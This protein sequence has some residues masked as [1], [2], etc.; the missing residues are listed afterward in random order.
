MQT[1]SAKYATALSLEPRPSRRFAL[2]TAA[3]HGVAAAVMVS[4]GMAWWIDILLCTLIAASAA[5]IYM[6]H[7]RLTHARAVLRLT[8]TRHGDWRLVY[9][10]G[11]AQTAELQGDSYVHPWLVVLNFSLQPKGRASVVLF[12]DSLHEEDF[13]RLRVRLRTAF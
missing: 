12:P 7:V 13:R 5:Y 4:A 9:A 6:R 10:D 3:T 8:W 2:F 1:S 11:V